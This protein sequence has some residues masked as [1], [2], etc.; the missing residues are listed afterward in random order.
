LALIAASVPSA[1]AQSTTQASL[2]ALDTSAFPAMSASMDVFDA[3]G[4]FLSGLRP[5]QVTLIEDTQS[6]ALTSLQ[7]VQPGAMFALALDPG[8][9]FAFQGLDAVNRY[10]KVVQ[11]VQEWAAVHPDTLGDD[12]SFIP[13]DATSTTHTTAALF[14]A[15]LTT[16]DPD[17]ASMSTSY[18]TLAAALDAVSET[19]PQIGMKRVVLYITSVPFPPSRT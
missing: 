7:E 4:N 11:A 1:R 16:Y 10:D 13:A 2:F 5:D 14:S 19:A 18:G 6:V 12:L 9:A 15:A 8:A 3:S 17:L